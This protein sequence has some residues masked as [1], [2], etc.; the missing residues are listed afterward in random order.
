MNAIQLLKQQHREVER[1]FK[2]LEACEDDERDEIR[3]L[4]VELA[5]DLASHAEIEEQF[6]YPA[7]KTKQ[8]RD[9]VQH[10]VE[11][12]FEVKQ[13]LARMLD[14]EPGANE[15]MQIC[16][17]LKEAVTD[18]VQEEENELMPTIRRLF[19][20]EELDALGE[21]MQTRYDELISGEP[22]FQIREEL[23]A[24]AQI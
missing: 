19:T 22:R 16:A 9:M 17:Q 23:N 20:K 21:E 15:F 14:L 5:D 2:E 8:T 10:S 7:V 3:R 4:F 18:H 11:E 13:L 24:P 12:H 6:F 1:L